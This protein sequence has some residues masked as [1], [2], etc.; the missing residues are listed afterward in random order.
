MTRLSDSEVQNIVSRILSDRLIGTGYLRAE[1]EDDK[2]YNGDPIIRV[3][4]YFDHPILKSDP[5]IESTHVIREELLRQGDD[6]YVFMS[7]KDNTETA[8]DDG[9][10]DDG[11]A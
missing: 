7:P 6:R 10:D 5:L 8:V 4:V 3:R 1:T 2:D 11:N 9:D